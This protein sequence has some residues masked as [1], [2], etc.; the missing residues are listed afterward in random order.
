MSAAEIEEADALTEAAIVSRR[1]KVGDRGQRY[2]VRYRENAEM[3]GNYQVLGWSATRSGARKMADTWS[4]KPGVR[5]CW[6]YDRQER[7]Q[8]GH[9]S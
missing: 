3:I 7:Q 4:K 1:E 5:K 6:I 9:W 8:R 2:E